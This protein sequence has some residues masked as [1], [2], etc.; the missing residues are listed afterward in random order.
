MWELYPLS[1]NFHRLVYGMSVYDVQG[2]VKN[3]LWT[4]QLYSPKTEYR[5]W[6]M[7][8]TLSKHG[9]K[10]QNGQKPIGS[11]LSV[12]GASGWL[13]QWGMRLLISGREFKHHVGCGS[14]FKKKKKELSVERP[15]R[16]CC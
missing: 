1:L 7:A 2:R 8:V 14:Y 16:K 13:S 15:N 3:S 12:V 5:A 4:F 10:L 6:C 9:T 11:E